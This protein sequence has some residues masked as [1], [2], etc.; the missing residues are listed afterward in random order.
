[1]AEGRAGDGL[2]AA[3][4]K[5]G[6]TQ[7][8][9]SRRA[10]I[11]VR[12]LRHI[13]RGQ[14]RNPRRDALERVARVVGYDLAARGR[15]SAGGPG[16]CPADPCEIRL[17]GPLTVVCAGL[18]VAMPLKLRAL[19]G[20]LA[21]QPDQ[22][23]GHEEIADVLWPGDA[24]SGYAR[25]VHT[26]AARLRRIFDQGAGGQGGGGRRIG[27]V[28]GGYVFNSSGARLDLHQFEQR[29]ARALQIVESDPLEALELYGQAL[30]SRQGRV[31]QDVPQLWHHPAVV[32]VAQ[33]HIDVTIDFADLALRLKLPACAVEHLTTAAHEEPLHESLQARMMLAL[34]GTG[35]RAAAL[36]L[37]ADLRT[38]L[39][40]ELGVEP[41]DEVWHAR[42][43][44]LSSDAF[45]TPPQPTGATS[46]SPAPAPARYGLG[47]QSPYPAGNFGAGE[48]PS[49]P[50]AR[51]APLRDVASPAQLPPMATPFVGR[52][53]QL[54][55][56]D[57]LLTGRRVDYTPVK[58]GVLHGPREV[59]KTALAVHWAHRRHG[60]FPDGQL[61]ADLRGSTDRPVP[62]GTV[63]SRFLRSIGVSA[64]WLPDSSEEA[65]A[66][67]RSL[68]AGRRFLI[69]LDD[70]AD[71]D[72]VRAL[73]PGTPGNL[74][75]ATSRTLLMDLVT[76][77][78]A[79]P[80]AVG[81]LSAAESHALIQA[82]LGTERTTTEPE[83]AAELVAACGRFPMALRAAAARLAADPHLPVRA[84]VE[85]L[86]RTGPQPCGPPCPP[87]GTHPSG[88]PESPG[89]DRRAVRGEG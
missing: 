50:P 26:Y 30:R 63:L 83:A 20:L 21:V 13:E 62:V 23:V 19:L 69:L 14:V 76:R 22:V 47:P 6:L 73:L 5:A 11:S 28:R 2:R 36:Q 77:E 81:V 60:E 86:A 52:R 31:L 35:R 39:R 16:A 25:L 75:L 78:G 43:A 56:L 68:V 4:I 45:K 17:L 48:H 64:D 37:F 18:P 49:P 79:T 3:R 51:A 12:T 15:R 8:E 54:D 71:A 32:R 33:R 55:A 70:V 58:I 53:Q 38:R 57:A 88:A 65:S 40:K 46:F 67:L 29:V 82:C 44:I 61:Y 84:V 74:V 34:A 89:E 66:L 7:E 1:M 72:Q 24:P 41:S 9:V 85:E 59:G 80:I 87:S 42:Q 10:G 27:T